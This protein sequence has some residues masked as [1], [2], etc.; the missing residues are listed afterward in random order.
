MIRSTGCDGVVIGRGC[1]GKPWLFRDLVDAFAGR[2]PEPAP[3]LG[4][5]TATMLDHAE[6][7]CTHMGADDGIRNFRKHAGWYLTGYPVGPEV[8]RQMSSVS[9][10]D[11]LVELCDRLDPATAQV[12]GGERIARGHTNGPI[13]VVLPHG[14]L[15]DPDDVTPPADAAVTTLSGG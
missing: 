12:P 2:Q 4:F 1:L 13:R 6:A 3:T 8:R 11:E 5:V 10:F 15:D 9:S 7:L 14:Y